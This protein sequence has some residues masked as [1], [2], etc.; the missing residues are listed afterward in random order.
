[1]VSIDI[2]TRKLS[3]MSAT[4]TLT[5]SSRLVELK[6]HLC[7]VRTTKSSSKPLTPSNLFV[8]SGADE[9]ID[10]LLRAFCRPGI[11][12]ILVCPPTY[13]MYTVSAQV[14]DVQVV[15]VPLDPSNDFSLRLPEV[16]AALSADQNIKLL[17][18]CSPG[19]PTGSLLSRTDIESLLHHPTWNG[20]LVVDEAY[21]DFA[22][23]GSSFAESVNDYPNLVVLQ[24]LSKLFGLAN[25]R[26]GLAFSCPE[27][28]EL[29]NK[30][31]SPYNISGPTSK[32]ANAALTPDALAHTAQVHE[33]IVHQRSR[34][35]ND[36]PKV[37]G[38][39]RMLSGTH[40]NFLLFEI[41][42][43]IDGKPCNRVA[44]AVYERMA[45]TRGVI[46]RFRGKDA[47]CFGCLRFSIGTADENT[48]LLKVLA[49]V[50]EEVYKDNVTEKTVPG[51][52]EREEKA[53]AVIA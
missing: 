33:I 36:L 49:E 20:I 3:A 48:K 19:N 24:T 25:I 21:I 31:K 53:S 35:V 39:G 4:Y 27:I 34:L 52:D 10:T 14:N 7:R 16:T 30:L 29:L 2:P 28:A 37:P 51:E 8:G 38:V 42:E 44:M 50:L 46:V 43:S 15:S 40:T 23:P 17:Y 9:A 45:K 22:P 12:K 41:L 32:I 47:G 5:Y 13:G 18:L 26:L 11:D 6:R 1:M